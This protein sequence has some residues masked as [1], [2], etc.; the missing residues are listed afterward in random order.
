MRLALLLVCVAPICAQQWDQVSLA[1]AGLDSRR[2]QQARDY[3]LTGGGSGVVLRGGKLVF[4]WGDLDAVY[5]LKSSSKSVGVTA[6]GLALGD[7]KMTLETK[8]AD[9]LA[10]FAAP[11][12]FNRRWAPAVTLFHLATQTA[13]FAKSG[14]FK[15]IEFEPGTAWSYS[16]GGPNWLADCL[17]TTYSQDLEDLLFERVFGPIGIDSESLRWRQHQ[18]RPQQ[19]DGVPRR[20]FGSGVHANVRAMARLGELYLNEGRWGGKQLIPRDF[21]RLASKPQAALQNLPVRDEERYPH[22]AT[23]YGLLWWNNAAGADREDDAITGVPRDAFWSWGL[24]DSLIVVIPSLDMVIARAGKGFAGMDGWN[25]DYER[26]KPFLRPLAY[27]A[28]SPYPPS[29]VVSG[30]RWDPADKIVRKAE[31]SDN[32]PTTWGD[33]DAQYTA[34]GDGW[35]FEPKV[36]KKLSL[37]FVRVTGDPLDPRGENLRTESGERVGQGDKGVK[38]S[39]LLM[40]DGVLYL[41]VRNAANSQLAWSDDR[42]KSWEWADWRLTDGFGAPAFLQFGPNY[43]GARDDFVY[44]YSQDADSAYASSSGLALMRAPKNRLREKAA[45]EVYAGAGPRWSRDFAERQPVLVNP[46]RVYRTQVSYNAGLGRYLACVILPEDDTRFAG[47]FSVFDAPEPW[48][49]WTKVAYIDQWDVGPGETCSFP[50]KWMSED[51]RTVHMLFSG[52]D[53]F[54]VRRGILEAR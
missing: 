46:G 43:A 52:D 27:A 45:W 18:Y 38:A 9:C 17:T 22:A 16:D 13:G 4:Q 25:A 15:P 28:G 20:E 54:S 47:G 42:G 31:G 3:A 51:G 10:D 19:L 24:H 50:T 23:H 2:L 40:V 48:G 49:P 32:W 8:A 39:G 35:G 26:L 44:A 30:I 29:A 5:D 37:G 34:Y 53:F 11:P 21:V 41:W 12:D 36:E 7:G 14:G 33:D 1:A 6:L